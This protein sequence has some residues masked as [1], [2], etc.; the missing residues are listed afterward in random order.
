MTVRE[1][2]ERLR[3]MNP[4]D[5]VLIFDPNDNEYLPVTGLVHSGGTGAVELHSDAD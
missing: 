3:A 1:L 5:V 2:I 4:D